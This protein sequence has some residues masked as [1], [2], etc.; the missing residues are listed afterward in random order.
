MIRIDI[1]QSY[2]EL[3]GSVKKAAA[4]AATAGR[5]VWLAALGVVATVDE[6]STAAFHGLVAKGKRVH[7]QA[8][9]LPVAEVEKAVAGARRRASRA[10]ARVEKAAGDQ[11]A[12]VLGRIGVPTR[13]EV[14][15]LARRV[16]DL[17]AALR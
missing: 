4:E 16:D 5:Q 13:N 17:A 1:P 6:T 12:N 9:A 14:K 3:P 11:F 7:A 8:P 15:D 2:R 10:R